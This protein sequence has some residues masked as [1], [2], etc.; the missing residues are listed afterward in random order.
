MWEIE[1]HFIARLGFQI[2][3]EDCGKPRQRRTPRVQVPPDLLQRA[4][5]KWWIDREPGGGR[6]Q[7]TADQ[8]AKIVAIEN[9]LRSKAESL[10]A[11]HA[12]RQQLDEVEKEYLTKVETILTPEQ[13]ESRKVEIAR[14]MPTLEEDRKFKEAHAK[15]RELAN[16]IHC[17]SNLRQIGQAMLMYANENHRQC[18]RDLATLLRSQDI[19]VKEFTCPSAAPVLPDVT[20]VFEPP[21]SYDD[22]WMQRHGSPNLATIEDRVAW[23]NAHSDFIYIRGGL[24]ADVL[25][26]ATT[27]V[28]YEKD[29]N[30][31]GD[32]M[33]ILYADGHVDF[34]PLAL[35]RQQI[36]ASKK[37][38]GQ[39]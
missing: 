8:R 37:S 30:H 31:S 22:D 34:V 3:F 21:K 14:S 9:D 36:E 35:A 6:D 11:D 25:Q 15:D 19:T 17:A 1:L 18:P 10:Q 12:S 24:S 20:N 26:P 7:L 2:E 4:A 33:D 5:V 27:V 13:I 16:R 32:G 29:T 39:N 23:V 38:N 28:C